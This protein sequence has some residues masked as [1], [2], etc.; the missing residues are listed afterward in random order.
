MLT[1]VIYIFGALS[2]HFADLS[3]ENSFF[4]LLLPFLNLLFLI[5]LVIQMVF[6][7]S[8]NSLITDQAYGFFDLLSDIW[9]LDYD[10][11]TQG[12]LPTLI[13]LVARLIE[14]SCFFTA[15]YYYFIIAIKFL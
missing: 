13:N 15:I 8:M 10:I 1:T 7:F 11:K 3:H 2:L 6:F 12:L 4:S 5:F 9:D 14:A